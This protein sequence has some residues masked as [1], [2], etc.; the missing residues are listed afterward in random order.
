MRY[1]ATK[2]YQATDTNSFIFK[3]LNSSVIPY[4]FYTFAHSANH[5]VCS[6]HVHIVGSFSFEGRLQTPA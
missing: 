6:T 1:D 2:T 4:A 5:S 3:Q